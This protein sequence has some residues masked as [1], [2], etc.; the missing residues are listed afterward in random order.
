[1]VM[2]PGLPLTLE[3]VFFA[4]VCFVAPASGDFVFLFGFGDGV[5]VHVQEHLP[6]LCVCATCAILDLCVLLGVFCTVLV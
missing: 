2:M 5:L 4:A 3:C 1:M 6:L